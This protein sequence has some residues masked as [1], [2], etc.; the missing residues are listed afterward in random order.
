MDIIKKGVDYNHKNKP[1]AVVS[2][3]TEI[4]GTYAVDSHDI[5]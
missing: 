1:T 4:Q 2:D 3:Y 5:Q